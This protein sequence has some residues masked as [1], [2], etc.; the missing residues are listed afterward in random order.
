ME[1]LES[2]GKI[3][4]SDPKTHRAIILKLN[5]SK[6]MKREGKY[7]I[8]SKIIIAMAIVS[9]SKRR[10]SLKK[11]SLSTK[12]AVLLKNKKTMSKETRKEEL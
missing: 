11:I 4:M 5:S 9:P 1:P 3:T 6:S 8:N 2:K 12:R 7:L 10:S